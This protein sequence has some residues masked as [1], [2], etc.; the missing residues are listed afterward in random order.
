MHKD[1]HLPDRLILEKCLWEGMLPLTVM[2]PSR[3]P[4]NLSHKAITKERDRK[5]HTIYSGILAFPPQCSLAE[6][7]GVSKASCLS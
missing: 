1:L 2:L 6:G 5:T 3:D 7:E 4:I